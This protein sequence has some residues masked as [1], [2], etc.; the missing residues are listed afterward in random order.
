[1]TTD[2]GNDYCKVQL[3]EPQDYQGCSQGIDEKHDQ[4]RPLFHQNLTLTW[5]MI[6]KAGTLKLS[7]WQMS[8]WERL[9]FSAFIVSI[10]LGTEGSHES[11]KF[12]RFPETSK[13]FNS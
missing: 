11:G 10:T 3:C 4:L 8:R 7:A 5:A 2:Q 12:R 9:I 1:M 13:S 6:V